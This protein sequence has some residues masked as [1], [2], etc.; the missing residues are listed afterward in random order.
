[1]ATHEPTT[2]IVRPLRGG[3]ITIPVGFRKQLGIREDTL[4]QMTLSDGALHITPVRVQADGP[5]SPWLREL[6]AAFAPVREE[7]IEL[8]TTEAE[9]NADI[10]AAVAAVR[11]KRRAATT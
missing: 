6:Y 10:E 9:L 1:V 11:A 3:Q 2:R 5:G 7:I 8:G 4:L